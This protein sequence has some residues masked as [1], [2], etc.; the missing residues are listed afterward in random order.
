LICAENLSLNYSIFFSIF[1]LLFILFKIG[2]NK[3]ANRITFPLILIVIIG[4]FNGM[5]SRGNVSHDFLRDLMIMIQPYIYI[6]LGYH[7]YLFSC[8]YKF[9]LI[10]ALFFAGLFQSGLKIF[11]VIKTIM[12]GAFDYESIRDSGN[13][14]SSV[15]IMCMIIFFIADNNP[16]SGKISRHYYK[17]SGLFIG[18]FFIFLS[19]T[20]L[21]IIL[22][23][24]IFK[25]LKDV[26]KRKSFRLPIGVLIFLYTIHLFV[27]QD[28]LN[29]FLEKLF[30]SL[31]EINS[32][33]NT[34][35]WETINSNWRGYESFLVNNSFI[36]YS[37]KGKLFGNGFG[38]LLYL[39]GISIYL[40]GILYTSIPTIHN[41]YSYLLFKTGVIGIGLY[42]ITFVS[43]IIKSLRSIGNIPNQIIVII[44]LSALSTMTVV[45]GFYNAPNSFALALV[46][47]FL[48]ASERNKGFEL[49]K[50]LLI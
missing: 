12:G 36:N 47:G 31:S 20:A 4:S 34:W 28:I 33:Q 50:E 38:S 23:A 15:I 14:S 5:L 10:D 27:P 44:S 16:L 7:L 25:L 18:T 6:M 26:K 21:L 22:P 13:L 30:N 49:N 17:L 3:H 35:T 11:Y 42:S 8:K 40:D 32:N 2:L 29:T 46:L 43:I 37:F 19:R 41:G 1:V 24:I 9:K 45:S 48:L 39:G